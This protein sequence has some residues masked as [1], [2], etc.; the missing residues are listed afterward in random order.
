MARNIQHIEDEDD[1]EAPNTTRTLLITEKEMIEDDDSSDEEDEPHLST[2]TV[3]QSSL[4]Q[5][6]II[7]SFYEEGLETIASS[8]CYKVMKNFPEYL[9]SDTPV[10]MRGPNWAR[11]LSKK[12]QAP[13]TA[14]L[15]EYVIKMDKTFQNMHGTDLDKDPKVIKR[16]REKVL[17]R[18]P[19]IEPEVANAF[20][21]IRLQVRIRGLN[22]RDKYV[23]AQ[24]KEEKRIK[25]EAA[26]QKRKEREERSRQ[27][28]TRAAVKRKASSQSQPRKE[29]KRRK[30]LPKQ[31]R[32]YQKNK[33]YVS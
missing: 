28:G 19:Y 9:S 20:G 13:A 16:F 31:S 30:I 23:Q 3:S 10:G 4:P 18:L 27:K 21:Q 26:A 22:R 15:K 14:T 11:Y 8:V 32:E 17:E 24:K 6:A 29:T 2:K 5:D 7:N 12:G 25:K 1:E 33:N